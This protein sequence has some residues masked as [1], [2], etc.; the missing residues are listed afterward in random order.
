M[1]SHSYRPETFRTGNEAK[2]T[3]NASQEHLPS[4]GGFFIALLFVFSS[5]ILAAQDSQAI[6]A[7][8]CSVSTNPERFAGKLLSI[9]GELSSD[10]MHVVVLTDADCKQY[11]IALRATGPFRG[12]VEYRKALGTGHPGTLDKRIKGT[13]VGQFVWQSTK[14]PKRI[15]FLREVHDLS[16]DQLKTR[17][18]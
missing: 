12:E 3:A 4:L 9:S 18:R 14:L 13:F 16:V 15:L 8:V 17:Q 6:V 7:T 5:S 2:E 10:G 1:A 11:G